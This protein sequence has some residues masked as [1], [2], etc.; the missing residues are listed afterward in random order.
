MQNYLPSDLISPTKE[1]LQ[2]RGLFELLRSSGIEPRVVNETIGSRLST[3]AES[4]FLGI[5]QGAPV[6]TLSVVTYD[7]IGRPIEFG[8]HAYRADRY[9][10]EISQVIG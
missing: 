3:R 10:F 1:D 6:L 7:K 4:R 9:A 2:Q 5:G 8:E